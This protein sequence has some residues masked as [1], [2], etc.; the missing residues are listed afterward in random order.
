MDDILQFSGSLIEASDLSSSPVTDSLVGEE[1]TLT[2]EGTLTGMIPFSSAEIENGSISVDS[3]QNFSTSLVEGVLG[4][5]VIDAV[6]AGDMTAIIP[7]L[8]S[9][10]EEQAIVSDDIKV[11]TIM[12][13]IDRGEFNHGG[14]GQNTN[15]KYKIEQSQVNPFSFSLYSKEIDSDIW[16][17]R[18]TITIPTVSQISDT[19][20]DDNSA[21]TV[22][23]VKE[24]VER[25]RT[26]RQFPSVSEFPLVG[27]P[28]C[29]YVDETTSI[30]YY[31]DEALTIYKKFVIDASSLLIDYIN[32][33]FD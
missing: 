20:I 31:F 15:T 23:A 32:A 18:D 13:F 16:V 1:T 10:T 9:I 33:N 25:K 4:A 14:S 2:T 17:L 3:E 28:N 7:R 6:N 8:F 29:I 30:A 19:T 22:G 5:Q 12:G 27:D 24:Y 26:F 21:P 11:A